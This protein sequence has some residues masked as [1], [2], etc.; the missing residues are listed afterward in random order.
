M[1]EPAASE[2]SSVIGVASR[3]RPSSFAEACS[4]RSLDTPFFAWL[5]CECGH[6]RLAL[7]LCRAVLNAGFAQL[8]FHQ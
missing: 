5:M 7:W 3:C 8:S 6:E 2:G 1:S 4:A